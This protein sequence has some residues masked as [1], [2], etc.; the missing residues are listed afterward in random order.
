MEN[1]QDFL[2]L[3]TITLVLAFAALITF[4]F[5]SGLV[6]LWNQPGKAIYSLPR[7]LETERTSTLPLIAKG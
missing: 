2:N 7:K 1:T 5:F 6:D 3:L 4:D